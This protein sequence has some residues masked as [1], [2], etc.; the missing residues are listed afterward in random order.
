MIRIISSRLVSSAKVASYVR[1]EK[2]IMIK[3]SINEARKSVLNEVLG[4]SVYLLFRFESDDRFEVKSAIAF[5]K[6]LADAFQLL[7]IF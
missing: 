5:Q 6:S 7:S 2:K 1:L 4:N 3:E